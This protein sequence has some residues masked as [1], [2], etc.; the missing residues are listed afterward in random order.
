MHML[1]MFY[2]FPEDAV[3][4]VP[5]SFLED[6]SKGALQTPQVASNNDAA[7]AIQ[8]GGEM[9]VYGNIGLQLNRT[10]LLSAVQQLPAVS[11]LISMYYYAG[12]VCMRCVYMCTACMD[13]FVHVCMY[14]L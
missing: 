9:M 1:K 14:T 4:E 12:A 2:Q 7:G 5:I 6:M 3:V 8:I 10:F 11:G 13:R